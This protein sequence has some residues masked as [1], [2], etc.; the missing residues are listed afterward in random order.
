MPTP[1]AP[2]Q[3]ERRL[4][5]V[6][7]QLPEQ[8]GRII[9]PKQL[10]KRPTRPDASCPRLPL[11]RPP[12]PFMKRT[13]TR[14]LS[15]NSGREI[16]GVDV[17]ADVRLRHAPAVRQEVRAID[18]VSNRRLPVLR[19]PPRG[20]GARV[21]RCETAPSLPVAAELVQRH[22][23]A[24]RGKLGVVSERLDIKL[25]VAVRLLHDPR[26]YPENLKH[27]RRSP[28]KDNDRQHHHDK[29]RRAQ[30]SR[31]VAVQKRGEG[32][33]HGAAEARPEEHRLIAVRELLARLVLRSGA[34]RDSG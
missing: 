3:Q 18:V 5:K 15:A 20:D 31:V 25:V 16:R 27:A 6:L 12:E 33:T 1:P 29:D 32:H 19:G 21:P 17:R 23:G 4:D 10:P 28:A 34:S 22:G 13:R 7:V 30:R 26:P 9:R 2:I 11:R 24:A 8:H 14:P